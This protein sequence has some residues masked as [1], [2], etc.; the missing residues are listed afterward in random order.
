MVINT[1]SSIG[2][3][4]NVK[5]HITKRKNKFIYTTKQLLGVGSLVFFNI[6]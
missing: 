2:W 5:Q 1:V 6:H 3:G 4:L